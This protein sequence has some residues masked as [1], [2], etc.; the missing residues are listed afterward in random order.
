MIK[1]PEGNFGVFF[2]YKLFHEDPQKSKTVQ[3]SFLDSVEGFANRSY[4][5]RALKTCA[6]LAI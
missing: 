1:N 5:R 3:L 2:A 4:A 6:S